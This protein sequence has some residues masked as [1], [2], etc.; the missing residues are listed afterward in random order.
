MTQKIVFEQPLNEKCRTLLRLS[1]LFEQFD[2]HM[3]QDNPWHSRAALQALLDIANLLSRADIKSELIKEMERYRLSLA[4]MANTPGV[5][6]YRLQ[7]ILQNLSDTQHAIK[8]VQGQLGA[9]LR[10]SDFLNSVLQRNS[11]PGG[12]FDFDLPQLHL[13]LEQ[14]ATERMLQFD[15]W[16]NEVGAVHEAVDLL[17]NLIRYSTVAN[18]QHAENGFY[19]H[20]L[21]AGAS[22]QMVQVFLNAD[23]GLYAEISGGKHRF[24]IRFMESLDWEQPVQ[25]ETPVNFD[26]NVCII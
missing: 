18:R 24:T 2:F 6:T 26:L 23:L 25:T 13:W 21:P 12:G 3:P 10:N 7:H 16:R 17:L 11:L 5:D 15:D 4:R 19:Q 9:S 1:R 8:N 20:A 22:I 14:P